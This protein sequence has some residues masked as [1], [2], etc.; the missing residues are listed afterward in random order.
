MSYVLHAVIIKKPVE[1]DEAQKIASEFIDKSRKFY[2]ET[3]SSYRFRN[4][5]KTKFIK[6]SFRTKKIKRNTFSPP[7]S[8]FGERNRSMYFVK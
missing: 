5:P 4:I 3:N 8:T 7:K 1:L 2:R 6:K